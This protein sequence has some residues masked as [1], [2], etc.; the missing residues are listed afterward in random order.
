MAIPPTRRIISDDLL[1]VSVR[2]KREAG[3][4]HAQIQEV[5][6][7]FAC[8]EHWHDRTGGIG[9]PMLEDIPQSRRGEFMADLADLVPQGTGMPYGASNLSVKDIWPSRIG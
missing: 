2:I 8:H 9:F 3:V 6:D 7:R 5:I 1:T 4:N